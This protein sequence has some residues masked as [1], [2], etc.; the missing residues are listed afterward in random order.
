MAATFVFHRVNDYDAWR[1]VYDSVASMQQQ[2]G[3]TEQ[4]VYRSESDP[5]SVL[6]F[7]RFGSIS[8]AHDFMHSAELREALGKAGVEESTLRIEFYNEA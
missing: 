7:H 6:V 1:K 4:A 2:G 8:Q 3:V 5:N